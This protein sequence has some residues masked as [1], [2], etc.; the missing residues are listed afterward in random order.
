MT[1]DPT[2]YNDIVPTPVAVNKGGTGATTA[3]SA[4]ANLSVAVTGVNADI[5]QLT[6]LNNL[7]ASYQY[8]YGNATL[9]ASSPG[10]TVVVSATS[11][12][13]ITLPNAN[14]CVGQYFTICNEPSGSASGV[15]TVATQGGQ[16]I[17]ASTTFLLSTSYGSLTVQSVNSPN[18][19]A[20]FKITQEAL[21]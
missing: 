7:K 2:L 17:N 19:G 18:L 8:V 3:S 10:T 6:A 9:T 21:N 13:T 12:P 4:R 16:A 15:V 1:Y 20:Y 11:A 5:T 14:T